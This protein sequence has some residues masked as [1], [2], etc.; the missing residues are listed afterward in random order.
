VGVGEG[1]NRSRA[2]ITSSGRADRYTLIVNW[3]I[4]MQTGE[5]H[6]GALVAGMSTPMLCRGRVLVRCYR[7]EGRRGTHPLPAGE[8]RGHH[9]RSWRR[10]GGLGVVWG[11]GM[12]RAVRAS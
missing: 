4:C 7:E 2:G 9:H 12:I 8:H 5:T 3:F 11:E 6:T 1:M 10:W